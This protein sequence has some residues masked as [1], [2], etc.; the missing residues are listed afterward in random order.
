MMTD[1]LSEKPDSHTA[2]ADSIQRMDQLRAAL[3]TDLPMPR[4]T[5]RW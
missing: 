5:G 4:A 2:D 1:F 3:V